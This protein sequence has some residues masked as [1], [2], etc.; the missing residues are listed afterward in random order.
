MSVFSNC[1]RVWK[2]SSILISIIVVLTLLYACGQSNMSA[3]YDIGFVNKAGHDFDEVS[4]Y[5]ES[6]Q[7]AFPTPLMAGG[8]A[9]E[10]SITSPIPPDVEVR[11]VDR[12]EQ[13]SIKVSL[14]NVPIV[15]F[16]SGT[17]YFVIKTNDTIE[18]EPVK[19]GDH[20]AVRELMKGLRPTGEYRFAF[21]NKTGYELQAVSVYYGEQKVGASDYVLAKSQANF[22]YSA[23]LTTACPAEAELRWTESG[24][25]HVVKVKLE[26]VPRGFEGRIFFVFEADGTIEIRPVKTGDDKSAFELLK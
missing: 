6:R 14:Q 11:I 19:F 12:G 22:T 8:S 20:A 26:V 25:P 5:S 23:P 18:V 15:G 16:Q 7:L 13:K 10:G 9:T 4:A 3:E 24:A 2:M 1:G 21:V 17:I